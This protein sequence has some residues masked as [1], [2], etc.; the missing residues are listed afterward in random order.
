M[1]TALMI[2]S[3]ATLQCFFSNTN[4]CLY[5]LHIKEITGLVIS[6]KLHIFSLT[7]KNPERLHFNGNCVNRMRRLLNDKNV[8]TCIKFVG[9]FFNV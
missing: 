7:E 8:I 6:Y 1:K 9:L 3:P 2:L 5:C 4:S